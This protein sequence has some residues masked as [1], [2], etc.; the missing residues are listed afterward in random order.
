MVSVDAKAYAIKIYYD[1]NSDVAKQAAEIDDDD[2]RF[3]INTEGEYKSVILVKAEKRADDG[4]EG[5][6]D[7]DESDGDEGGVVTTDPT[8]QYFVGF[9]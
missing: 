4:D 6:Q 8:V 2:Y 3:E 7:L 5:V 1:S 9:R